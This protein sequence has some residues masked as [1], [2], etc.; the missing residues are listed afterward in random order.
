MAE[1]LEAGWITVRPGD[2]D[3]GAIT[4]M[5]KLAARQRQRWPEQLG[6]GAGAPRA[7]PLELLPKPKA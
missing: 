1:L 3:P 5:N 2:E 4:L 7:V 6:D